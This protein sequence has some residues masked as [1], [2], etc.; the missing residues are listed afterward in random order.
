MV[1]EIAQAHVTLV[2]SIDQAAMDEL[3]DTTTRLVLARVLGSLAAAME[4]ITTSV[5]AA[6]KHAEAGQSIPADDR[7]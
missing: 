7:D 4:S 2:P 1:T 6:I 5:R 3:I